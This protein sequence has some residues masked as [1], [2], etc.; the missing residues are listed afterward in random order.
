MGTNSIGHLG[1]VGFAWKVA[2]ETVFVYYCLYLLTDIMYEYS[3]LM[4][5][6]QQDT[7]P[8]V[9]PIIRQDNTRLLMFS[10]L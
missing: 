3:S 5:H 2:L 4:I 7:P 6:H 8:E 9:F 1:N 10:L